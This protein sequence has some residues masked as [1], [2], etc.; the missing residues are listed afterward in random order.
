[1]GYKRMT[2]RITEELNKKLENLAKKQGFTKN[3][4]II[5]ILREHFKREVE[6]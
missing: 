1:M 6:K 3:A 5:Q 4:L 2:I